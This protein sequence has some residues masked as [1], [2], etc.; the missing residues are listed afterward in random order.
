MTVLDRLKV[1]IEFLMIVSIIGFMIFLS[2]L[3][4]LI[5]CF[6]GN[7]STWMAGDDPVSKGFS[8]I[9][10]SSLSNEELLVTLELIFS[11]SGIE[12]IGKLGCDLLKL[13]FLII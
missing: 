7:N 1:T 13:G 6:C 11:S 3:P 9:S 8:N 10:K 12:A 4:L 5:G 2:K